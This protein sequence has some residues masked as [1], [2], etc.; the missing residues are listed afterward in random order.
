MAGLHNVVLL[1][2]REIGLPLAPGRN[3][4]WLSGRGHLNEVVSKGAPA[5]VVEALS[6]IHGKLGGDASVLGAKLSGASPTPDLVHAELG[7]LIEVD[8]VQHFT[9]ARLMS[10]DLYPPEVPLGYDLEVYRHQVRS[11]RPKGD[12][13]FAHKVAPDFP[14]RGG[15]QAQR[16]YNDAL[17]DLLAPTFTGHP[18][19]RIAV[20]DR[21]LRGVISRLESVCADLAAGRRSPSFT[22]GKSAEAEV[23][24]PRASVSTEKQ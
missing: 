15:R 12:A 5:R 18:L 1:A 21:S 6:A 14:A 13:A 2:A 3:V 23:T 16:A 8:E 22:Y 7:A 11:W 20:P 24:S 10:F 19:I 9:T 17:R 4:P